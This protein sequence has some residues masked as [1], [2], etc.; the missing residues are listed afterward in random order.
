MRILNDVN[1]KK[2]DNISLFL[3][4]DEAFQMIAY[5]E[6]LLNNPGKHHAHLSSDDY[7]KEIT[8]CVYDQ[9]NINSFHQ[10]AKKLILEDE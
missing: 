3:T 10:R 6:D 7:Q 8:L 5:L 1:D 4:K 2:I 9:Q